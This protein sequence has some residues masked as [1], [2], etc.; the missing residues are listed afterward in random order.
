ME[1]QEPWILHSERIAPFKRIKNTV[2][3]LHKKCIMLFITFA[4]VSLNRVGHNKD[5]T[6]TTGLSF[7]LNK[8]YLQKHMI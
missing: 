8:T 4:R 7:G 3:Y 2:E 6:T 5:S 1:R